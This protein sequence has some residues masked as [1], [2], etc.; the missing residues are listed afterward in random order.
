MESGD[1]FTFVGSVEFL[2]NNLIR[3]LPSSTI[4][5]MV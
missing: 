2:N 4:S 3:L 1:K 5:L